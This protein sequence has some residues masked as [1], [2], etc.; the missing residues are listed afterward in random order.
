MDLIDD[1]GNDLAF[2]F[3]VEKKHRQRIDSKDVL[4]LISRIK[5]A[6]L[7]ISHDEHPRPEAFAAPEQK[8]RALSH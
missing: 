2:A 5:A 6:L 3:L 4:A 8:P 7:P 1:L